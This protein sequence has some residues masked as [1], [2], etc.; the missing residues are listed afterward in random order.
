MNIAEA[1]TSRLFHLLEETSQ[2]LHIAARVPIFPSRQLMSNLRQSHLADIPAAVQ[3]LWVQE[4]AVASSRPASRGAATPDTR[5]VKTPGSVASSTG[6]EPASASSTQLEDLRT[7]W[8]LPEA[9]QVL[10]S[11]TPPSAH[12]NE[13]LLSL[14]GF[15]DDLISVARERAAKSSTDMQSLQE[16]IQR[17]EQFI[18]KTEQQIQLAASELAR[19]REVRQ[20]EKRQAQF[21]LDKLTSDIEEI[22]T[23]FE[24]EKAALA[25][26]L[27]ATT[28]QDR[29]LFMERTG[30]ASE[31]K[32]KGEAELQESASKDRES[33]LEARKKQAR[34]ELELKTA[35]SSYDSKLGIANE[36]VEHARSVLSD[37]QSRIAKLNAYFSQKARDDAAAEAEDAQDRREKNAQ[38]VLASLRLSIAAHRIMR[39]Y[40]LKVLAPRAAEAQLKKMKARKKK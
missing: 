25:A 21:T 2:M 8:K 38:A 39:Y 17:K 19:Q 6:K 9:L 23:G 16:Y 22:Q 36:R 33:E 34:L 32:K 7:M 28:E 24:E 27:K 30:K 3:S 12:K 4:R 13:G 29:N 40:R 14:A 18:E 10:Q 31:D 37:V 15:F 1:E 11:A 5:R 20:N 35:I 26:N